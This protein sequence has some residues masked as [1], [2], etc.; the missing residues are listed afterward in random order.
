MVRFGVFD[1][2]VRTGELR[3]HG[4]K[5]KLHGKPLHILQALLESPGQVVTRDELRRRLWP[6]DVF[7]DFDSGL[8]T[9]ANRLR[10]ALGDSADNPRYIETFAALPHQSVQS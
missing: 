5:L 1:V 2:D 7:V 10:A 3:K 6:S 8:N 9:A 4:S